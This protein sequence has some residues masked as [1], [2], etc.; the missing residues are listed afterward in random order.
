M[1]GTR[2]ALL[3]G[4]I[5]LL[6]IG[7]AIGLSIRPARVD[8]V[9]TYV[10]PATEQPITP[11]PDRLDLDRRK[12]ELGRRLFHDPRLS[13]DNS[14]SCASCHDLKMFGIDA[15]AVALGVDKQVGTLNSPTVLNSAFGF[16]Q[17]FDGRAASLEDQVEGP[18]HNP[19]E[20]DSTWLA[21]T[22]KLSRDAKYERDFKVIW[23][24]GLTPRNIQHA[25]AEFER[26][27][28]TPDSPFDRYLKG[29]VNALAADA[30]AG[31]D[32]FRKLGC[33][34]CHQGVNM[35]GNM[36]A[37]LGVMGDY[38]ADRG[39]PITKSDLGRFNVTGREADRY[40]FKVP[41]LRN[42]AQT[43][44]YF[45]DGSIDTLEAAVD[46]MS[47]YQLGVVL[48]SSD[49]TKLVAFLHALNGR[50]SAFQP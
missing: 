50:T 6:A 9:P 24:D 4:G 17:F 23:P 41:T 28:I 14:V 20:M 46:A 10:P 27:L 33:I 1:F 38:F 32:T 13:R 3:A 15:L 11:I 35:G 31:W 26:S 36:Y 18:V 34:A 19:I 25:I 8:A 47:R 22:E 21:V 49:R 5:T 16:R 30:R 29:D 12:V 44:P 40:V 42:I 7:G 43:A 39:K 2:W 37:N 45:H 48:S